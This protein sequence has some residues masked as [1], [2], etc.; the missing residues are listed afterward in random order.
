[1]AGRLDPP[2]ASR[3]AARLLAELERGV[4]AADRPGLVKATGMVVRSCDAREGH[5]LADAVGRYLAAKHPDEPWGVIA[6]AAAGA[7]P[8]LAER[9]S[10]ATAEALARRL[11]ADLPARRGKGY[12]PDPISD[13]RPAEV[14]AAL[15]EL[16]DRLD[17]ELRRPLALAGV[18][19]VLDPEAAVPHPF[20]G[21]IPRRIPLSGVLAERLATEDASSLASEIL[22]NTP[23]VETPLRRRFRTESVRSL[24]DRLDG[25]TAAA[26]YGWALRRFRGEAEFSLRVELAAT[27]GA[28]DRGA[29]PAPAAS[30]ARSVVG[31]YGRDYWDSED[32]VV[33]AVRSLATRPRGVGTTADPA[34]A[35]GA[36]AG[37]ATPWAVVT[38]AAIASAEPPPALRLSTQE[39]VD[40]LKMPACTGG[41]RAEVLRLLGGQVGRHF[42]RVYDFVVWAE[43]NRPDLDLR[44]PPRRPEP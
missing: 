29:D 11:I 40:L 7:L 23:V 26:A 3:V 8:P 24:A 5:R 44:S 32:E 22:R 12:G 25:P 4:R 43:Q 14:L 10:P 16:V 28:L 33:A 15:A 21:H 1:V 18:R 19:A 2:T 31:W 27:L 20:E 17:P 30:V 36:V 38:S 37:A 9:M 34:R 35:A 41:L 42:D 13:E 39:L 6:E